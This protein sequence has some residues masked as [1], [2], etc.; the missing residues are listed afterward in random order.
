VLERQAHGAGLCLH[1]DCGFVRSAAGAGLVV[2]GADH[3][4]H[5]VAGQ[6][7]L[8]LGLRELG[9]ELQPAGSG[10]LAGLAGVD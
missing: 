3:V 9:V 2:P 6:A 8:A 5:L 7:Q 1:D 10:F 4:E